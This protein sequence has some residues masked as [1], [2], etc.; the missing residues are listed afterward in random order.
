[1]TAAQTTT[2]ARPTAAPLD[3]LEGVIE[4]VLRGLGHELVLLEWDGS[5]RRTLRLYI[6]RSDGQP[7]TVEDCARASRLVGQAVE[8]T[9]VAEPAVGA[10]LRGAYSLEVSSPGLERPLVRRSHF[11]RFC[12]KRAKVRLRTPLDPSS[13]R[14]TFTGVIEGTEPDPGSPEDDRQGQVLLRLDGAE[15]D[16]DAGGTLRLPIRAIARA[17]LVY[18]G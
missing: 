10:M 7:V 11:E 13:N 18:E 1:M 14:R 5:G 9:E 8:A 17:H 16:G 3:L 4:P 6:D 15:Q 2:A 12:G